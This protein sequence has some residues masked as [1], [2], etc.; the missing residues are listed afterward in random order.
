MKLL[1]MMAIGVTLLAAE[2]PD[3][4]NDVKPTQNDKDA[5]LPVPIRDFVGAPR[6]GDVDLYYD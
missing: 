5:A 1:A 6:A 3:P 2:F 4:A